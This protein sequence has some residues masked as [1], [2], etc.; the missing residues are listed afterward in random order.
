MGGVR[1]T[2]FFSVLSTISLTALIWS[3]FHVTIPCIRGD[4]WLLEINCSNK[5]LVVLDKDSPWFFVLLVLVLLHLSNFFNNV[6][7]PTRQ[8][9]LQLLRHQPYVATTLA[10]AKQ[11]VWGLIRERH[12]R[13]DD[14]LVVFLFLLFFFFLLLLL[15]DV[16]VVIEPSRVGFGSLNSFQRIV[17]G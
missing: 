7:G 12:P 2:L 9:P 8:H 6:L 10:A 3:R 16:F 1:D 5:V 11:Q 13:S 14:E 15:I 4:H 17:G